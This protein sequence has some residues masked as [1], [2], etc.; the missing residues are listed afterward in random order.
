MSEVLSQAEIDEL[1][2]AL[3]AGNAPFSDAAEEENVANVK[4]YDFRT[5]N[6]F[7]KEQIRTFSIVFQAFSQLLSN[8]LTSMLRTLCECEVLSIE[9]CSF[10]E[11]NNSLPIPVV[12]AVFRAP[13]MNGSQLI[14]ISPEVAYMIISRLFGGNVAG[15]D[16]I[17]QFTEIELTVIERVIRQVI[18]TYDEAWK[19][20]FDV[21]ARMERIESSAQFVQIT[22]LN[23][24]VA[25]IGLNLKI[26][27]DEGII[28]ICIPH[29]AIEPVT[30]QLNSR[31]L[32]SSAR[33]VDL[34]SRRPE[35]IKERLLSTRVSLT[36]FFNTT[37]AT[38]S[39][40]VN[41]QVGDVVKLDHKTKDPLTVKVEHI[42]KFITKVGT[43]DSKTALQIVGIIKEEPKDE[44]FAR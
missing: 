39:D 8:K 42:P 2:N 10:N 17:K 9:E 18:G 4:T 35:V 21:E 33:E 6:R 31:L 36:A 43:V 14:E 32:H 1:L 41:L 34:L 13:P 5:A 23:E 12:L 28:S 25:I 38:V 16:N 29:A 44:S 11:F 19:K 30:K 24:P 26:G 37:S 15:L 22:G 27:E 3:S 20:V 7:P 40:I